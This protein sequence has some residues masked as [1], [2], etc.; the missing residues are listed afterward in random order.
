MNINYN[1][2]YAYAEV[3]TIL[4]HLGDDYKNKVPKNFLRLFKDERKF[5]YR[6][7]ID[8]S[9]PLNTQVRQE[10]KNIIAF[11]EYKYWL[12]DE[13]KK[14]Q[15]KAKIDENVA[16]RKES[17]KLLKMQQRANTS[18][19]GQLPLNAQIDRALK[20]MK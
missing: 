1:N 13:T 8:F 6:P 20:N 7:E 18:P 9:K 19:D 12:E 2:K 5:G 10:T 17:E 11:L 15:L 16:K 4:E 3:W 14:A